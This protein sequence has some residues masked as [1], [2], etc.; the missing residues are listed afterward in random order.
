MWLEAYFCKKSFIEKQLD[1]FAYMLSF[2]AFRL[3]LT[4]GVETLWLA[5]PKMFGLCDEKREQYT[6]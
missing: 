2:A 6:F 5:K 3:Q 1:P 4:F